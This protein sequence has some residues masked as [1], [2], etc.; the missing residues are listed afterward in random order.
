MIVEKFNE[1]LKTTITDEQLRKDTC[2]SLI[3]FINNNNRL[4]IKYAQNTTNDAFSGTLLCLGRKGRITG[5]IGKKDIEI[6]EENIRAYN[7]WK[8]MLERCY[9]ENYQRRKPT[10]VGCTVSE[11]WL[12][13]SNFNNFYNELHTPGSQL[14]KDILFKG[15]KTYSKE[16]CCFV[17]SQINGIVVNIDNNGGYYFDPYHKKFRA[18]LSIKGKHKN[19]GYYMTEEA[20]REV[21]INKKKEYLIETA[22]EYFEKHLIAENV[23]DALIKTANNL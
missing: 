17:P 9:N 13:F 22:M 3:Q 21:Y 11:E 19:L 12:N 16:T 5:D 2:D 23:K 20:A 18:A 8:D 6:T 14:D 15:N 10:Y 7:C 4:I 1:E